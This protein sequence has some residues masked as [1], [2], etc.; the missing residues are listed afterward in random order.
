MTRHLLSKGFSANVFPL[1]AITFCLNPVMATLV[2]AP[3]PDRMAMYEAVSPYADCTLRSK[4]FNIHILHHAVAT[5]DINLVQ[6]VEKDVPLSEA[7]RTALEHTLLHIACLPPGQKHLNSLS[8]KIDQSIHDLRVLPEPDQC[9]CPLLPGDPR[10]RVINRGPGK[11]SDI[12]YIEDWEDMSQKEFLE[13]LTKEFDMQTARLKYLLSSSTSTFSP[14][15]ISAQDIH[16]NAALHYLAAYLVPNADA[17][18]LI[19][20]A[21]T[22]SKNEN[23]DQDS[24]AGHNPGDGNHDGNNDTT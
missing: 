1:A 22:T 5:L 14:E 8:S 19:R 23:A 3:T 21:A 10:A 6:R 9:S 20:K 7:G 11:Y 18:G 4:I 13:S 2:L 12:R 17:I 15:K 16:G 24:A